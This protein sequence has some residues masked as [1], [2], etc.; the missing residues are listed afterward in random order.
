MQR[1]AGEV[2]RYR[3]YKKIVPIV[4]GCISLV[5]VITY[6]VSLL[7]TRFGSF[8]ISVNKFHNYDYGIALSETSDFANP[9]AKLTCRASRGVTNIDGKDLDDANLGSVDG[10]DNAKNYLCY[11]FYCKNTGNE[12]VDYEYSINI[13]NATMGIEKAARV[14]VI[15]SKNN[16]NRTQTD[17]ARAKGVDLETGKPIP[18][19]TPYETTPFYEEMIVCYLKEKDFKPGD[20]MKYT[21]VLWLEG[22]DDE[23]INDI[24]GGTFKIDMKFSVTSHNGVDVK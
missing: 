11:T 1:T 17:Y 9:T 5:M 3:V 15:I 12:A 6:V 19:T 23:C 10:Q 8:T 4:L 21:L 7:Y 16:E 24:I 2:R 20:T 14:R 18:E 13:V 22:N